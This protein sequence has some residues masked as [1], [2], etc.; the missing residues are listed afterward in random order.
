MKRCD[1]I[2]VVLQGD[3]GKPRPAV[4]VQSNKVS[5]SDSLLVCLLTSD[6]EEAVRWYRYKIKAT[7]KNGLKADSLIML[8]KIMTVPRKKCGKVIGKL[9]RNEKVALNSGLLL[10]LGLAD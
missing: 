7:P 2:T 6:A 1:L 9:T 10:M 5:E 8:D 3:Y 4:V